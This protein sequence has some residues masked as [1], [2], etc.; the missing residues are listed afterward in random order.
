M[1]AAAVLALLPLLAQACPQV[2]AGSKAVNKGDATP[3]RG[4]A[5]PIKGTPT[6]SADAVD[7]T[8]T[9]AVDADTP[10]KAVSGKKAAPVCKV[11]SGT[12]VPDLG[13]DLNNVT[14]QDVEKAII[15]WLNDVCTV[16][17]FLNS[18]GTADIDAI[19]AW[20]SDEPTQLKTLSSVKGISKAGLDAAAALEA[21]FPSVPAN[22]KN[23]KEG[24]ATQE[25]ATMAIN[26]TRCC[27]VLPNV[28][29]LANAAVEAT[30]AFADTEVPEPVYPNP[31]KAFTC[32]MGVSK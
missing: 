19:I 13:A 2:K 8:A 7:S 6:P 25:K 20:G 26:F 32:D 11:Q 29:I 14:A 16:D 31:C 4:D 27:S 18:P 3:I 15:A 23:L 5:T 24:K 28:K 30:G 10:I 22:L 1:K 21:N 17:S 9:P 12:N